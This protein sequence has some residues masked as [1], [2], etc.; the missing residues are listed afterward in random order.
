MWIVKLSYYQLRLIYWAVVFWVFVFSIPSQAR[1]GEQIVSVRED[2]Q[3][4][5]HVSSGKE[6]AQLLAV[7]R[8]CLDVLPARLKED[9]KIALL[10]FLKPRYDEY[11]LSY[12]PLA[13]RGG[14]KSAWQVQ[15]N[16]NA[17]IDMLKGLGVY[18]TVSRPHAYRL[19]IVDHDQRAQ[20]IIDQLELLSGCVQGSVAY[21]LLTLQAS[22][23]GKWNAELENEDEK[24]TA[25][26]EEL[27]SVWLDL[28]SEYFST[29]EGVKPFV[30]SLQLRIA[31]WSTISAVSGFC[32]QLKA[33]PQLVDRA[34]LVQVLAQTGGL[35]GWWKILSPEPEKI[36]QRLD[37]YTSNHGLDWELIKED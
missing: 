22:S 24:W 10:Q 13:G 19:Q 21:P 12:S 8:E 35:Q 15:V 34:V 20:K 28:W 31:G 1:A 17:L 11:V 29:P 30:H 26:G 36:R 16:T 27:A 23:D 9:R 37:A 3:G 6:H 14:S 25:A 7:F 18:Y 4:I 2:S 32:K 5:A 33:W